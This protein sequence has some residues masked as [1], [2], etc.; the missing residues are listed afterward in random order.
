MTGMAAVEQ[1]ANRSSGRVRT[2][3]PETLDLAAELIRSGEVIVIPTD[4]VYGVACDPF[5]AKAIEGIFAAKHRPHTKALQVLLPSVASIAEL[6]LRLPDPLGILADAFLPGPFSPICEAD[7]HCSLATVRIDD[8]S[9][10]QGVRVPDSDDS[11]RL[12][13][14][15][16]PLAASSANRSGLP[17]AQTAQQA[18]EQLGDSVALY[19]DAGPTPGPVA[20]TVVAASADGEDGIALLR[21]GVI[22]AQSVHAAI[23][24][25][26]HASGR[27]G[28]GNQRL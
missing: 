3:S 1:M 23:R 25:A 7:E 5:N 13:E 24:E 20:S 15:T 2:I 27:P 19:I 28:Q 14:A 18:Y 10:T 4:T 21:E 12:L 6:G 26:A 9:R 11:R 22:S 16:G 17:S 8:G